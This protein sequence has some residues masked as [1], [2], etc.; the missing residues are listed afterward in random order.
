[1]QARSVSGSRFGRASRESRQWLAAPAGLQRRG[2]R[3]AGSGRTRGSGQ[4]GFF[5]GQ[6]DQE[7]FAQGQ[8]RHFGGQR[9]EVLQQGA[10]LGQLGLAGGTAGQV[11]RHL[12]G[13]GGGQQALGVVD[14]PGPLGGAAVV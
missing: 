6:Q 9:V 13:F 2:S 8:R 14:Q 1:M 7:V 10:Q 3:S 5:A 12:R 4:S 11:G